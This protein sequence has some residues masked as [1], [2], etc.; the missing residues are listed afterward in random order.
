MP[1]YAWQSIC[2]SERQC[3]CSSLNGHS[4]SGT[5][6]N[7]PP[8]LY[9]ISISNITFGDKIGRN[10]SQTLVNEALPSFPVSVPFF[11][12]ELGLFL[13]ICGRR[14]CHDYVQYRSAPGDGRLFQGLEK[15]TDDVGACAIGGA[16]FLGGA[17][18]GGTNDTRE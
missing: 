11:N 12:A 13:Q 10:L 9:L 2:I 15:V 4:H 8:F 5:P 17:R 18:G 16:L 14:G 6:C 3:H 7:V 1:L